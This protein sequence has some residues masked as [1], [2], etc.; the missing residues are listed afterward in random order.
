MRLGPGFVGN[1]TERL[2]TGVLCSESKYQSG[3]VTRT[4]AWGYNPCLVDLP[5]S[6]FTWLLADGRSIRRFRQANCK[7]H[8][9]K[10]TPDGLVCKSCEV[11]HSIMSCDL[12]ASVFSPLFNRILVDA[13]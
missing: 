2:P 10:D 8:R 3:E 4:D 13:P 12:W 5:S 1:T 11:N 7:G 6:K 9:M